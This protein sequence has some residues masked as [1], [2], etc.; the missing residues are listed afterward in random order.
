MTEQEVIYR[1]VAMRTNAAIV[2][3]ELSATREE[4]VLRDVTR[5]NIEFARCSTLAEVSEA[6]KRRQKA[7]SQP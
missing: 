7:L 1:Y 5:N 4:F 2:G 6:V 3:L